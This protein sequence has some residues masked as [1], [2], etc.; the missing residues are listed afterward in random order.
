MR[1]IKTSGLVALAAVATMAFVGATS[2]AANTSTQLCNS[3]TGLTCGAGQGTASVHQVLAPGTVG[4][5]LTSYFNILCLG[6]L[7]EA[8]TLGLGNPQQIHTTI[9]TFQGCGTSSTH[10]NCTVTI[11]NGQQPLFNLLKTG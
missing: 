5:M 3:H 1:L 10:S 11:P 6:Y 2:V 4:K 9:Q 7:V 8:T